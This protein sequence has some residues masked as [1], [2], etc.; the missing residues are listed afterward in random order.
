M[1][2]PIGNW[3]QIYLWYHFAVQ[4]SAGHLAVF[5]NNDRPIVIA[6]QGD[7][8]PATSD[9]VQGL[10]FSRVLHKNFNPPA[11]ADPE[12]VGLTGAKRL[13]VRRR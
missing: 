8:V 7:F 5:T 1:R 13:K 4:A 9:P 12:V 3:D 2:G 6:A 10:L 11:I